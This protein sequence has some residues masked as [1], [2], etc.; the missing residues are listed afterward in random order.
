MNS[1]N[2]VLDFFDR[3][4]L[5]RLAKTAGIATLIRGFCDLRSGKYGL[6]ADARIGSYL[7]YVPKGVI[8]CFVHPERCGPWR[9]WYP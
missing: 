7:F 6:R 5:L 9:P 2:K 4:Y 1:V 3:I 8:F